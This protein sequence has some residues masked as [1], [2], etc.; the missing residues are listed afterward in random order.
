MNNTM[1]SYNDRKNSGIVCCVA[2]SQ[3]AATMQN[4]RPRSRCCFRPRMFA[5]LAAFVG[6]ACVTLPLAA[7]DVIVILPASFDLPNQ[8]DTP[9][10]PL[11][12]WSPLRIEQRHVTTEPVYVIYTLIIDE[13]GMCT[14]MRESFSCDTGARVTYHDISRKNTNSGLLDF[15]KP[16]SAPAWK[17]GVPV[18]SL[19]W[20]GVIYNAPSAS[21]TNA[22]ATPR[23]RKVT[24]I[25]VTQKQYAAFPEGPRTVRGSIAIDTAGV[26]KNLKLE[27]DATFVQDVRPVIERSL[28]QWLF[29]PA[30]KD[31]QPVDATL[32]LGFLLTL[33]PD[34]DGVLMS[35]TNKHADTYTQ[36]VIIKR[37]EPEYPKPALTRSM[38]GSVEIRFVVDAKGKV[39]NPEVVWSSH[40]IF[41][42]PAIDAVL[43]WRFKPGTKNGKLDEITVLQTITFTPR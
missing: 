31:G 11:E 2:C 10:A 6:M 14:G 1:H 43:K 13:K 30:R 32:A 3:A 4:P 20:F 37:T 38:P 8:Y 36:P 23:L 17:N 28:A 24:P 29:A 27:S 5:L 39:R 7:Q 21:K 40:R 9:P 18:K 41:E 16:Q 34:E 26:A 35:F 22:D 42:Q 25:L 12:N 19:L 33:S 15:S